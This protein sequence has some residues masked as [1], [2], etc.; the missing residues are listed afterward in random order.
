M[1][2]F[3]GL[4]LWLLLFPHEKA[5]PW[6]RFQQVHLVRLHRQRLRLLPQPDR[7]AREVRKHEV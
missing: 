1:V 7:Q 5:P 6:S 4:W 3:V 2:R